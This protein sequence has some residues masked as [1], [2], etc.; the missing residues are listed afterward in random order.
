MHPGST[1]NVIRVAVV[2]DDASVCRA[3]SRLLRVTGF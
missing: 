1:K 2:D 3:F